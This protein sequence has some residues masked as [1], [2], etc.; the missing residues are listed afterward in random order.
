MG[1]SRHRIYQKPSKGWGGGGYIETLLAERGAGISYNTLMSNLSKTLN[2]V[3][4]RWVNRDIEF[5]K[6][7]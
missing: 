6:D 1:I 2:K 4:E 7:L 5:I 3:G